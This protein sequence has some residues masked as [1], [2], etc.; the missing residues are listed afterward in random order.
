LAAVVCEQ[1]FFEMRQTLLQG[2]VGKQFIAQAH[3]CADDIDAHGNRLRTVEYGGGHDRTMFGEDPRQ[4]V[5]AA[6]PF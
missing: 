5:L 4:F 6:S 1:R 3:K 2:R